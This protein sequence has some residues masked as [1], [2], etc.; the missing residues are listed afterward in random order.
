MKLRAAAALTSPLL[1]TGCGFGVMQTARPLPP[2]EI[3]VTAGAGRVRN[4]VIERQASSDPVDLV[5]GLAFR[6]GVVDGFDV[7]VGGALNGGAKVDA[8]YDVLPTHSRF[9]L[10]PRG[11]VGYAESGTDS[12]L[13]AFA[14]VLASY[15]VV[16]WLTPYAGVTYG[17][18]WV[19][20]KAPDGVTLAHDERFVERAGYG[21][22]LVELTAGLSVQ[23]VGAVAILAE[24][25]RS[26][27]AQNDE[28]DFFRFVP[29]T[30]VIGGMQ[31]TLGK[32]R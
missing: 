4:S 15:D 19:H 7:G 2:G 32:R 16:R 6:V 31:V 5:G 1:A 8:K 20:R 21:D 28:G 24:V 23:V 13:I 12:A 29:S 9:A 10:S 14:G 25:G 30:T 17:T 26:V 27:P 3:A 11:G 18:Y 22:G